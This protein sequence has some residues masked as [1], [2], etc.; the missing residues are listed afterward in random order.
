MA[1][2]LRIEYPSAVYHITSRGNA[3]QMIF[4]DD[5]NR[6]VFLDLLAAVVN[7][8]K[9]LCHAYCLMDNHYRLLLEIP[10]A[11]LSQGMRELNYVYAQQ[12]NRQHDRGGR[13]SLLD[14]GGLGDTLKGS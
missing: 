10:N 2:P 7:R 14:I 5:A 3:K 13:G 4:L 6:R 9:W 8:H 12:F 11:N 1:R